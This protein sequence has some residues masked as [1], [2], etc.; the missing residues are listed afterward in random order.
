MITNR[1]DSTYGGIDLGT[2]DC[3]NSTE[4]IAVY[5]VSD[6]H[7]CRAGNCDSL[8][9]RWNYWANNYQNN[10]THGF[11]KGDL[12]SSYGISSGVGGS[13]WVMVR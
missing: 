9:S 12:A 10:T 3:I 4:E 1:R 11:A 7:G 13:V 6:A 2:S 8:V 5:R